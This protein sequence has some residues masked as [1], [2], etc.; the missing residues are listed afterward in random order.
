[1][2]TEQYDGDRRFVK[3]STPGVYKRGNRYVV[4]FRDQNGK[5]H[6]RSAR[7]LAEAR[8]IKSSLATD[9]ARGEFRQLSRERFAD[10]APD[11]IKSYAGRTTR[12]FREQTRAEYRRD[13]GL[14][15]DGKPLDPPRGAV[16]YFGGMR[17]AEITP[18]DV[19][20]YVSSLA[21]R[22]LA[23]A[24]IRSTI[25]P[26]RALLA[27]AVEEDAIRSNPAAGIRVAGAAEFREGEA[28][29]RVKALTDEEATRL[30]GAVV[31]EHR[32]LIEFLLRTGLRISEALA[33]RWGDVD[34]GTG[35]VQVRRRLYKGLDAPKSKFGRRDVRMS[36]ELGRRLW[37]AR[38]ASAFAGDGDPVFATPTGKPL[39]YGN[40]YHRVMKPAC[41]TAG[42]PWAAFH[43]LRHTCATTLFR[44]G[45]N[46]KQVQKALG[47]HS[48]AFTMD[49]YVHLLPDDQPEPPELRFLDA[50]GS[51]ERVAAERVAEAGS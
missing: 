8:A 19:K 24:T 32:L 49:T 18:R 15:P 21:A 40:L 28:E 30:L 9:V 47:H 26:L 22:G 43:T 45:W 36:P 11:W 37:A 44:S 1:M 46:P 3:T 29:E 6:K 16:A 13:L 5:G 41:R 27:T 33:L 23:P 4:R 34:L 35:R 25:A 17:L 38:K 10:Y 12:G 51:V 7:T 42:V 50:G 20:G 14:A 48:A 39:D 31:P 2:Q